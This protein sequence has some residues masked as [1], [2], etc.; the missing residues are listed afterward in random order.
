MCKY[1][2]KTWTG[3]NIG[4]NTDYIILHQKVKGN[5]ILLH[6]GSTLFIAKFL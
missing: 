1:L 2:N 5:H 3:E 6:N 4:E